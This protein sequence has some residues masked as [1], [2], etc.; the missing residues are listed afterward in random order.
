MRWE[1]EEVE[2]AGL[3]GR[4]RANE[5]CFDPPKAPVFS[6]ARPPWGRTR[7]PP[8]GPTS[9]TSDKTRRQST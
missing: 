9:P 8:A 4:A 2:R 3:R 6:R 7:A 5:V 1:E